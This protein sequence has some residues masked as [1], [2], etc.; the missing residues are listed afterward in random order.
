MVCE[1]CGGKNGH[2][3]DSRCLTEFDR[4]KFAAFI[5]HFGTKLDDDNT[6]VLGIS[7][8]EL[9]QIPTTVVVIPADGLI[10]KDQAGASVAYICYD[11][12]E[13]VW[14]Y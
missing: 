14:P 11:S 9:A 12:K 4:R 8:R 10:L 7:L 3:L 13:E 5:R 2:R 1:K 6:Y